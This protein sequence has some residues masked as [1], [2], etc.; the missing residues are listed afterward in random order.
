MIFIISLKTI[1]ESHYNGQGTLQ[2][3][4]IS[5][6]ITRPRELRVLTRQKINIDMKVTPLYS[7]RGN[8]YTLISSRF[9]CKH[10]GWP[11]GSLQLT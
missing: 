11:K 6:L 3:T 5:K 10:Q 9:S 2:A 1:Q 8:R 4:R 7:N